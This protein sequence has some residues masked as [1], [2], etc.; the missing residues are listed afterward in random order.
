[1]SKL[2]KRAPRARKTLQKFGYIVLSHT[3]VLFSKLGP[4]L[5]KA[6]FTSDITSN[7][8]YSAPISILSFLLS[9]MQ[10][11]SDITSNVR[12]LP[13]ETNW[14]AFFRTFFERKLLRIK[15]QKFRHSVLRQMGALVLNTQ[16]LTVKRNIV[17]I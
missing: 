6:Q 3:A 14:S 12:I 9:K 16:F 4:V 5:S 13:A 17:Q 7:F 11:T 1:M 2:S 10:Y 15:R 8:G